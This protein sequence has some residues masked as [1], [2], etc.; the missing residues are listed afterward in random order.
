MEDLG[1][2]SLQRAPQVLA[3]RSTEPRN[4]CVEND[5]IIHYVREQAPS[6][7]ESYTSSD[8]D[9][10]IISSTEQTLLRL[11]IAFSLLSCRFTTLGNSHAWRRAR[12][13]SQ[14]SRS[15]RRTDRGYDTTERNRGSRRQYMCIQFVLYLP[16]TNYQHYQPIP[17]SKTTSP[18]TLLLSAVMIAKPHTAS[19]IHHHGEESESPFRALVFVLSLYRLCIVSVS[20]L[21]CRLII[22][23]RHHRLRHP[24]P[25]HGGQRRGQE[26]AGPRAG[27]LRTDPG[28]RGAPGGER[29]RRGGAVDHHTQREESCCAESGGVGW[30]LKS[31]LLYIKLSTP[32]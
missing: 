17:A 3:N 23:D 21:H 1:Q 11:D 20:S 9:T 24:R 15:E 7:T 27:R 12:R 10:Q 13:Q 16:T 6:S 30:E 18:L 22:R 26:A 5:D 29:R 8:A 4:F 28:V 32:R 25:R 14:R 19:A 31:V 2:S